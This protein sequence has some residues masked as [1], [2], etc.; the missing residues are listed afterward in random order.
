MISKTD[1]INARAVARHLYDSFLQSR[2]AFVGLCSTG[3][4]HGK[5][6]MHFVFSREV[7]NCSAHTG[8]A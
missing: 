6:D 1:V 7:Q 4:A 5:L 2:F 8:Y 3:Y